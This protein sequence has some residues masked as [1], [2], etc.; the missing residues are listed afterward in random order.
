MCSSVVSPPWVPDPTQRL[1]RAFFERG[2]D[3]VAR[4]LIGCVLIHAD[5]DGTTA[6]RIVETEA[7][8][9][10]RDLASH[11]AFLR[12]GGMRVMHDTA[13]IVYMYRSYGVHAMFNIVAK[14]VGQT[15]AVLVRALEPLAGSEI[16]TVRRGINDAKKLTLG[17]GNL[18]RAMGFSL[19][20][21]AT[22]LTTSEHI[23]VEAGAPPQTIFAGPRIG[24]TRAVD[25]PWRFFDPASACI[26]VHRRGSPLD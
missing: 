11:A 12:N 4:S 23:W 6:G 5:E 20:H 17:P 21:H 14:P 15:G 8:G 13:A 1:P 10:E 2:T 26:S 19:E 16:M 7:Y 24:I 25:T 3:E 22:D 18:C 9:D